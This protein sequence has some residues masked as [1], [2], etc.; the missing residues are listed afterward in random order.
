MLVI[1]RVEL[2]S[3]QRS[4]FRFLAGMQSAHGKNAG[5]FDL[6]LNVTV[7][8]EIPEEPVLVIF[9]RRNRRHH[10]AARTPHFWFVGYAPVGM[11]PQDPEILLMN[12]SC[13]WNRERSA[14]A[15]AHIR[16]AINNVSQ[17]ITTQAKR[18]R[19]HP[20]AVLADVK[21]ILANLSRTWIAIWHDHLGQRG[22]IENRS[23]AAF[24]LITDV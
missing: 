24:V 10:Q 9:N 1:W 18:V 21:G 7:L 13:V 20:H 23:F 14:P 22:S 6:E 5:K 17:A 19:A 3:N 15:V 12:T 4:I 16:I 2:G 11:F 8:I